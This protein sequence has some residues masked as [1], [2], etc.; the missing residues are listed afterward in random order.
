MGA[1][2]RGAIA[3]GE[4]VLHQ[5][6]SFYL[7]QPLVE[8]ARLEQAQEWI[9][10][11]LGVSVRSEDLRLPF[12]PLQVMIWDTPVKPGREE[13]LSGVVLDWPRRWR[14]LHPEKTAEETVLTL[15]K[16][17][18]ERYY[19]NAVTFIQHSDANADWFLAAMPPVKDD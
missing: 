2:L 11:S 3:A 6:A 18:F 9:G 12:S 8:A 15:R 10:V 4:L 1:P 17:G 13:L 14:E 16:E 19:D 5:R 7:G